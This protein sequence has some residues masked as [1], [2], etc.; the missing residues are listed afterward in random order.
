[1][2]AS[3]ASRSRL[4]R[5]TNRKAGTKKEEGTY[6][7]E[8]VKDEHEVLDAAETVAL[9]G[10]ASRRGV[11]LPLRTQNETVISVQVAAGG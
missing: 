5:Q 6:E 8:E 10:R 3:V 2:A 1:M 11:S 9:H 7:Y 4:W